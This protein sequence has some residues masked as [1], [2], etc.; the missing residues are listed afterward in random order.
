MLVQVGMAIV[1][2]PFIDAQDHEGVVGGP[3]KEE[4]ER[5]QPFPEA[6]IVASEN[7]SVN[8]ALAIPEI[9]GNISLP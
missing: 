4:W 3:L 2:V 6:S 1:P 5:S 8:I 7:A 9:V